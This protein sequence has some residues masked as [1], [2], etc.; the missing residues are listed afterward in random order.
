MAAL[1]QDPSSGDLVL[2][3]GNLALAQTPQVEAAQAALNAF[4]LWQ[5]EWFLDTTIGVPYYQLIL[6][7][8]NVKVATKALRT[9]LEA[10]PQIASVQAF[11]A[12]LDAPS[13]KL[14][15]TFQATAV[16]GSAVAGSA[17]L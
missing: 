14:T 10:V 15:V 1:L 6:G 11:T 4:N 2:V 5:G 9:V 17:T 13:R 8:K 3:N 12:V 7:R 16:D